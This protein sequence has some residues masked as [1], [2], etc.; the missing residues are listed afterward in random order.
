MLVSIVSELR[1]DTYV[2]SWSYVHHKQ[3]I[4]N[5]RTTWLKISAHRFTNTSSAK[6]HHNR[7]QNMT[8]EDQDHDHGYTDESSNE[9]SSPKR[10][11]V[12]ASWMNVS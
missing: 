6:M 4:S 11:K 9:T 10:R 3:S 2:A 1:C 8:T 12:S 5:R 7:V